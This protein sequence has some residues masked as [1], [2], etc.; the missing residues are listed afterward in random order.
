M[1]LSEEVKKGLGEIIEI[2]LLLIALGVVAQI[3]FGR[4]A[5]SSGGI[6]TNLTGLLNTLGENG[7]AGLVA[8][9]VILF[10]FYRQRPQLVA[11]ATGTEPTLHPAP[12]RVSSPKPIARQTMDSRSSESPVSLSHGAGDRPT[13]S[14]K[15]DRS[16][17]RPTC[18]TGSGQDS[19][20]SQANQKPPRR[21]RNI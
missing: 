19:P 17:H 8:A 4:A 3:L 7:L 18:S 13:I 9:G 21:G 1:R 6:V 16:E 11:A 14:P 10:L 20:G 15:G 2:S 12:T 5:P